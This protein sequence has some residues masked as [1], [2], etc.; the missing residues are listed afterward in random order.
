MLLP[1]PYTWLRRE[2]LENSGLTQA[3]YPVLFSVLYENFVPFMTAIGAILFFQIISTTPPRL[4]KYY[5][6]RV[7]FCLLA[8]TYLSIGAS[9]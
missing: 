2:Y 7:G 5:T 9:A 6:K 1:I 3:E 8:N 4:F